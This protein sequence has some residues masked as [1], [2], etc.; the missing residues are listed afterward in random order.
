MLMG[1]F[2][3]GIAV[4]VSLICVG[5]AIIDLRVSRKFRKN[6]RELHKDYKDYE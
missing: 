2:V 6:S 3:L 1:R 5:L 4:V